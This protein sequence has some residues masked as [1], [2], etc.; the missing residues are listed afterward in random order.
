MSGETTG[1]VPSLEEVTAITD[2]GEMDRKSHLKGDRFV[3]RAGNVFAWLFPLLMVGIVTQV[4]MRKLGNNQAWLDDAQWWMYGIAMMA[5]F[6][7]AITTNSHVRVDIFHA[8]FSREKQTRIELFGLGWLLLPFLILMFDVLVHYAYSSILA[9]EGSDSP[10]GLHGLF[11]LKTTL[12][13]MFALAMLATISAMRRFLAKLTTPTLF[14]LLLAGLPGFIFAAFRA[15]HYVLW[16][17]V[18]FTQPDIKVRKIVKEPI[19]DNALWMGFAL[20]ALLLAASFIL[21][22]NRANRER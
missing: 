19:M 21:S 3:I 14:S 22:R 15:A 10:N 2:P 1:H 11:L 13:V 16:W 20:I 6:A 8:H 5:G 18:R 12:P 7:Y 9:L 4:I 17:F